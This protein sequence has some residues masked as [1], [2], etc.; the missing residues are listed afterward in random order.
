[1]SAVLLL[2]AVGG[3]LMLLMTASERF[4][5]PSLELIAAYLK[6]PPAVAGA[7]LLSFGNGAPDLFTQLAA[8]NQVGRWRASCSPTLGA[9]KEGGARAQGPVAAWP[10]AP[11]HVHARLHPHTH[12]PSI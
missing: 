10:C 7:T 11:G 1:V 4:F 5:C 3:L 9:R 8:V 6:M 12:T 2:A